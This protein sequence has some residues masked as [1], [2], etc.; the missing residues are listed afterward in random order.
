[1]SRRQ[2]TLQSDPSPADTA[3]APAPSTPVLTCAELPHNAL[4]GL[5]GR[6]G[7]EVATV[8]AGAAIPGSHWGAPEAGIQGHTLFVR[9]DTPVH[10][11]LHEGSHLICMDRKRRAELDTDAGGEDQEEDAVC[12]LQILL[13]DQLPGIDRCRLMTDMDTWGYSF[14]LGSTAAWFEQDADEAREWLMEN[15]LIGARGTP[16]WQLR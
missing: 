10:S 11:A 2:M 8:A 6:F 4:Q 15:G 12:Y 5:F 9:G 14:R 16:T 1:M 7:L 3:A 13:A